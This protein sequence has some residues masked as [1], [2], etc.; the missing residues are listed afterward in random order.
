ML[1]QAC[2]R[3][4]FKI[5]VTVD[6]RRLYIAKPGKGTACLT[7]HAQ[8]TLRDVI[9]TVSLHSGICALI[10]RHQRIAT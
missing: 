2:T 4:Q 3:K 9:D 10:I 8:H 7:S 6:A 1:V 5:G